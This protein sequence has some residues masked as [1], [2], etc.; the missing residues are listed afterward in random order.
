M[1]IKVLKVPFSAGSLNHN[2]YCDKAPDAIENEMKKMLLNESGFQSEFKFETVY[3]D[4]QN[5]E[6]SHDNI[7]KA[8]EKLPDNSI[9]L[10]GDHSITYPAFTAFKKNHPD[11]GIIIF[12]A[13]PDVQD[14]F[15]PPTHED[16]LRVIAEDGLPGDKIIIIG[17]R[18]WSREEKIFMAKQHITQYTMKHLAEEGMDECC[19]AIMERIRSWPAAY[20]SVD[21]D[22]VDPS[23]APGTGYCEPG[24]LTSRQLI[25]F[26]QRLKILP[27]IK[28]MDLVEVS[29]ELDLRNITT[30]LAAKIL[31][32][33]AYRP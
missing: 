10:G 15:R 16:Y 8:V 5:I 22:A 3:I 14:D 23:M 27:Q 2:P 31:L 28:M 1:T 18:V 12:D 26:I 30:R 29:P 7:K 19:N 33:V 4:Q 24:G 17:T 20:L 6:L 21:I 25:R 13:H 32:E 9:I 11:A